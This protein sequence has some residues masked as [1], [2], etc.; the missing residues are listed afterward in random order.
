[1]GKFVTKLVQAN[2]GKYSTSGVE[3][4]PVKGKGSEPSTG[5]KDVVIAE[6]L[7]VNSGQL[8]ENLDNGGWQ[9]S[10]ERPNETE[11]KRIDETILGK[12]DQTG[13]MSDQQSDEDGWTVTKFRKDQKIQKKKP[14]AK[15]EGPQG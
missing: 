11:E 1:M 2:N 12:K 8:S 7:D 14:K 5:L 15:S 6:T 10:R 4:S 9:T 13:E 3:E